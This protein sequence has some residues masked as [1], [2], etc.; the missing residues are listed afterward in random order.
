MK[1]PGRFHERTQPAIL[2]AAPFDLNAAISIAQAFLRGAKVTEETPWRPEHGR[3][4]TESLA[5]YITQKESEQPPTIQAEVE[6][7]KWPEPPQMPQKQPPADRQEIT[8]SSEFE[9]RHPYSGWDK[10]FYPVVTFDS[11]SAEF[12]LA[13]RLEASKNVKAWQRI[14]WNVPLAI[15]Y[16]LN[17]GNRTYI[18][19]FI[20]VEDDGTPDGRYWIVEGKANRDLTDPTVIAKRDAAKRWVDVVNAS[21]D[22]PT[23]W[24]YLLASET[25]IA[26]AQD[27]ND[28]KNAGQV[29][30]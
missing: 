14:S 13:E 11:Y 7:A 8:H 10:S 17:E 21:T 12:R 20:V 27:W 15:T 9:P 30:Q 29:H 23:K 28:L 24:G 1:S 3:L 6:L 25:V 16:R 22:V 18:P 5:T 19:D 4:A 26:H 2:D